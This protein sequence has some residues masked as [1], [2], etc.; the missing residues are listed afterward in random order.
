MSKL[1]NQHYVPRFYLRSFRCDGTKNNIYRYDKTKN[2]W[3]NRN[4][5]SVA[6]KFYYYDLPDFVVADLDKKF[7]D[8]DNKKIIEKTFQEIE[9]ESSIIYKQILE[10]FLTKQKEINDLPNQIIKKGLFNKLSNQDEILTYI[11]EELKN[12][13]IYNEDFI[14]EY[15][16]LKLAWFIALQYFR[17]PKIREQLIKVFELPIQKLSDMIA[18][19]NNDKNKYKI[20]FNRE[21]APGIQATVI[22]EHIDKMAYYLSKQAWRYYINNTP[23]PLCISDNPILMLPITEK[24]TGRGYGILSSGIAFHF[25]LNPNFIITIYEKNGL[26]KEIDKK[27]QENPDIYDF[28]LYEVTKKEVE[29]MNF[30]QLENCFEQVY[31][32]KTITFD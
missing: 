32:K 24:R 25:I 29:D 14:D 8:V 31:S 5:S 12:F 17:V 26:Q 22:F 30:L 7:P 19:Q 3:E 9:D 23:I 18:A 27:K 4:I 15:E 21:Y 16:K 28:M 20:T 11:N 13:P 1:K 2:K 6:S 10:K